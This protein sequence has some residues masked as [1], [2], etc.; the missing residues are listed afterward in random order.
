MSSRILLLAA[1]LISWSSVDAQDR[2]I[3]PHILP[4]SDGYFKAEF[5]P[6][7]LEKLS[8]S[9]PSN[10]SWNTEVQLQPF[11]L[12]ERN[13]LMKDFTLRLSARDATVQVPPKIPN[14]FRNSGQNVKVTAYAIINTEGHVQDVFIEGKVHRSFAQSAA[15]SIKQWRFRAIERDALAIVPFVFQLKA[16]EI[17]DSNGAEGGTLPDLRRELL[18]RRDRDRTLRNRLI[19]SG[20]AQPDP[21]IADELRA[22]DMSNTSRIKEI[23]REHGWPGPNLVGHDGTAAAWLLVQHS[24]I[25]FQREMLPIV[26]EAYTAG[27]LS[28][29]NYALLFDRVLVNEGKAQVFG[30]QG[31]WNDGV[32]GLHPIEDE[33]NVDKRR[34]E[35]GLGPLS[36]YLE[37]LRE[38]YQSKRQSSITEAK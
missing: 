2:S 38:V 31:K 25:E 8:Q 21:E 5:P 22:V 10:D 16:S 29:G 15:L 3:A 28:G 11:S 20:A 4:D 19:Q 6:S 9:K 33:V 30:S 34:A 26:K 14:Q 1:L 32:L 12:S 37:R 17:A 27:T 36:E 24:T 7:L 18:E 13:D 23:I 35:V